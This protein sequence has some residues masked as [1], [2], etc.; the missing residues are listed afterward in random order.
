MLIPLRT[1]L[2]IHLKYTK[3]VIFISAA[4]TAGA[5]VAVDPRAAAVAAA[6]AAAA[7]A[8]HASAARGISGIFVEK[9]V[10]YSS[11]NPNP[12]P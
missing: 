8:V 5:A 11:S 2:P 9:V 1:Q 10:I 7:A 4:A 3:A 6:A 12:K